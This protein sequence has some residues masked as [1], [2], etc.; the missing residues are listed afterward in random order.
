MINCHAA[1]IPELGFH[2]FFGCL[3]SLRLFA[4]TVGVEITDV[5]GAQE[6]SDAAVEISTIRRGKSTEKKE[7]KIPRA[8]TFNLL[9]D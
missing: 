5:V 6:M 8:P 1:S 4:Y 7:S 2:D 3:K 9:K